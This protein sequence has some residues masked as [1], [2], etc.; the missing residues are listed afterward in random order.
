MYGMTPVGVFFT[1]IFPLVINGQALCQQPH[2]VPKCPRRFLRQPRPDRRPQPAPWAQGLQGVAFFLLG[3]RNLTNNRGPI[4]DLSDLK[5]LK[6]RGYN[7][8]QIAAWEAVGCNLSSVTW[9]E[10][11]TAMQQKLIDGQQG[12]LTSFSESKFYEV[13]KY[14]TLTQHVFST[15]ILVANQ[16]WLEGLD[17]ED[18]EF[19]LGEVEIAEQFQQEEMIRQTNELMKQ[20]EEEHGTQFNELPPE[21]FQE[22]REIMGGI[23][24]KSIVGICGQE[25]FDTVMAY[26]D[27]AR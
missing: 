9:N 17:P 3:F 26:V 18:R 8:I 23:T 15:D 21:T 2:F 20:L 14:V 13:Q 16:E 24:E 19:I 10:L 22:M 25:A 1:A 4:E 6:I 5:G 12:A 27:E 7:P 11:F